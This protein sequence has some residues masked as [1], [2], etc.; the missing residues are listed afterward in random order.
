MFRG[1]KIT[2]KFTCINKICK[3]FN[4][5][6]SAVTDKRQGS[7]KI[8]LFAELYY[9]V[10]SLDSSIVTF[11]VNARNKDNISTKIKYNEFLT[12]FL[13]LRTLFYKKYLFYN[14]FIYIDDQISTKH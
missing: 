11:I 8:E 10:L 5:F 9:Y 13:R 1:T 4:V 7:I 14:W 6:Y 12:I 3:K 2:V